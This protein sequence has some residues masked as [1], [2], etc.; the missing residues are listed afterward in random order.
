M[1]VLKWIIDR[2]RGRAGAH[3]TPLGLVPR[4][5]DFDIAGLDNFSADNFEELQRIDCD[6]WRRE[7]LQQDE[8]F[9]RIYSNLPKEMIFQKELLVAR[10]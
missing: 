10:L 8:L 7:I 2:V 4:L 6:E 5:E 9:M 3:E 1:R